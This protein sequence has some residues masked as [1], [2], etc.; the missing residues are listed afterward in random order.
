MILGNNKSISEGQQNIDLVPALFCWEINL[1]SPPSSSTL[2]R[3]TGSWLRETWG[4]HSQGVSVGF[5]KWRLWGE[6]FVSPVNVVPREQG[7][8]AW[9]QG[10]LEQRSSSQG[11][12]STCSPPRDE[13]PTSPWDILGFSEFQ[14]C[15]S[16]ETLAQ[17]CLNFCLSSWKWKV[18]YFWERC[19]NIKLCCVSCFA[20]RSR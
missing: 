11:T 12:A 13:S 3:L 18:E 5:G 6:Q 17:V 16:S 8:S 14:T 4:I 10:M 15:F 20:P 7:P 19:Q 1:I 2:H 9:D